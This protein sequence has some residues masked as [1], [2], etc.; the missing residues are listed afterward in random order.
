MIRLILIL[1][2][3]VL[4]NIGFLISFFIRYGSSIPQRNLLPYTQSFAFLTLIC[5]A[6]LTTFGAYGN[7][8]KSSWELLKKISMGLFVSTLLCIA[9][10]YV[11]RMRWEAF[12]TSV[13][14]IS[15]F[16]NLLL[17][18]KINQTLLKAKKR[19]KKHVI[20]LG[21]GKVDSIVKKKA[22]VDK[23][24]IDMIQELVK[25]PT[26]DEIIVS[27]EITNPKDV[28]LLIYLE[29][30]L[31]ADIL[32]SPSVYMGLLPERINGDDSIKLLSTFVGRQSDVDEFLIWVLDILASLAILTLT[33]LPMAVIS[34]F[35]KFT[36]KGP[37]IYQQPRVGK[38]GKSFIMFK[39]RTMVQD[40]EKINGLLPATKGD[41]RITKVG[42]ILRRLRLDELPQLLNILR[43]EMSLVG[44]RPENFYRVGKHK[45]LQGI[46]L[47][48]KPGL[49]G[50]AQVKSFYD[51][52]PKHKLK[53]DYL[54]IQKRAFWLNVYILFLTIPVV[55][56]KKGW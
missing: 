34:L 36:S 38:D 32:F 29:Q 52:H 35:I 10:I 19:I 47:A 24:R 26:V 44:P 46:R 1:T 6:S 22:S 41:H 15:F 11:F 28:S 3:C 31:K 30:K 45:A 7:R 4:L 33:I 55:F 2:N 5:I 9:F 8:F 13:F 51:L 16:V 27:E 56:S 50:M 54:Y 40:A 20:I 43:G 42:R 14:M 23:I 37:V 18:F 17:I 25:Y 53:Y 21:G 12:P 49:T 39:F 48:V